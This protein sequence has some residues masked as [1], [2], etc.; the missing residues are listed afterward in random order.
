[1]IQKK[2]RQRGKSYLFRSSKTETSKRS[3]LSLLWFW[4]AKTKGIKLLR[5][6]YLKFYKYQTWLDFQKF[7]KKM[8]EEISCVF[9][10]FLILPLSWIVNPFLK[11]KM[12]ILFIEPIKLDLNLKSTSRKRK[13]KKKSYQLWT[14]L[15]RTMESADFQSWGDG[16][17]RWG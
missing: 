8:G 13:V 6:D 15:E 9:F 11:T 3:L 4:L 12:A 14:W 16:L 1:M 17:H 5:S 7:G 2:L 10:C